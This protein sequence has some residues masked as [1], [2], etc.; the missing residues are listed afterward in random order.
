MATFK[1]IVRYVLF[2]FPYGPALG[3]L[4]VLVLGDKAGSLSAKIIIFL[5]ASA[6]PLYIG[7]KKK[8]YLE[9]IRD[10]KK[11]MAFIKTKTK[12]ESK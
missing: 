10:S 7:I 12:R 6:L 8:M 11:V 4:L 3:V 9:I 1:K 2:F 5:A